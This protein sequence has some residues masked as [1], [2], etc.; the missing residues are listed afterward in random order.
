MPVVFAVVIES[1]PNH[2]H[3]LRKGHHVVRQVRDLR[4]ERA[5]RT[6]R[7]IA[8]RLTYLDLEGGV[9]EIPI[10]YL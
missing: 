7:V 10:N 2:L 3:D 8:G 1:L 5:G 6:P 9:Q 4:H